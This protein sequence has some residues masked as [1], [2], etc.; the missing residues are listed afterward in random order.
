MRAEMARLTLA[1]KIAAVALSIWKKGEAALSKRFLRQHIRVVQHGDGKARFFFLRRSKAQ[2]IVF[3]RPGAN[4]RSSR[5][6][7]RSRGPTVLPPFFQ[8]ATTSCISRLGPAN[9]AAYSSLV[10]PE[11]NRGVSRQPIQ[12]P[13]MLSL[14]MF[15]SYGKR[16]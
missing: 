5:N 8:M 14:V 3:L 6:S 4:Q 1:R 13:F 2:F 16:L 10:Y 9:P 12:G 11:A 7:K 15:C